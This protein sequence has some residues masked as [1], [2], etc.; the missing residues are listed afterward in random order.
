M[1]CGESRDVGY[2]N[3]DMSA[4][5]AVS[6]D[7]HGLTVN[8]CKEFVELALQNRVQHFGNDR[9]KA[10]HFITGK[11]LHSTGAPKL[12]PMVLDVCKEKGFSASVLPQNEGVIQVSL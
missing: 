11:G 8:E 10:Y 4:P 7:F 1:G 6:F 2:D 12:K 3:V 5:M 9:A